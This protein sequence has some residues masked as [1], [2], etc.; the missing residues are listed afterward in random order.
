MKHQLKWIAALAAAQLLAGC[1]L[2]SALGPA[3]TR[4]DA[5]ERGNL[6]QEVMQR[7][8]SAHHVALE[9]HMYAS[10]E[11]TTGGYSVGG[12]GCGCN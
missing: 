3:L 9:Q 11:S 12:G 10:K 5:T 7:D 1:A 4:V 6:A 8:G 2:P